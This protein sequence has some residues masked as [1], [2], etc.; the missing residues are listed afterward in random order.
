[1]NNSRRL[2]FAG[3]LLCCFGVNAQ[4][5]IVIADDTIAVAGKPLSINLKRF[6][7]DDSPELVE[8]LVARRSLAPDE[9]PCGQIQAPG[10]SAFS[11][12]KKVLS[13][14]NTAGLTSI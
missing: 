7:S 1:M 13:A 6:L 4:P 8:A 10:T 5:S 14:C 12:I 2:A 9:N 3:T 11:L